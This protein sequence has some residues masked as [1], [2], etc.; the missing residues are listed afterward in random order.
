MGTQQL[1]VQE[2]CEVVHPARDAS[3]HH[4]PEEGLLVQSV[5]LLESALRGRRRRRKMERLRSG[6]AAAPAPPLARKVWFFVSLGPKDRLRPPFSRRLGRF[7]AFGPLPGALVHY[8]WAQLVQGQPR[9]ARGGAVASA[10]L[11][12]LLARALVRRDGE[13]MNRFSLRFIERGAFG[14]GLL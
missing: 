9:Q 12:L 6:I 1:L 3:P 7:G 4:P 5:Q 11:C 14:R 10:V 8:S 2:D 13:R